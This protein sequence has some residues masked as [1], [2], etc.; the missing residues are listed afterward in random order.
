LGLLATITLKAVPFCIYT[1][2]PS[3]SAIFLKCMLEIMFCEG[4]QHALQFCPDH[5][6]FVR[7]LGNRK[8]TRAKS[9]KLISWVVDESNIAFGKKFPGERRLCKMVHCHDAKPLYL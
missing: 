9:D 3:A 2:F 6:S 1:P 8:V 5:L 7:M 4:V